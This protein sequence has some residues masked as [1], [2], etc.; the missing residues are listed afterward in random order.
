MPY[1][2]DNYYPSKTTKIKVR[3]EGLSNDADW[4]GKVNFTTEGRV[5]TTRDF[6]SSGRS[7]YVEFDNLDPGTYTIEAQVYSR[8][9][10][11]AGS[12]MSKRITIKSKDEGGDGGSGGDGGGEDEQ[13]ERPRLTFTA[14]EDRCLMEWNRPDGASYIKYRYW[15]YGGR[16][17]SGY[18]SA[19]VYQNGQS[20]RG[21]TPGETYSVR[22]YFTSNEDGYT[23]SDDTY[24]RR[25]FETAAAALREF[26]FTDAPNGKY[27]VKGDPISSLTADNWNDLMELI[28][29]A[30]SKKTSYS[31]SPPYADRGGRLTAEMYNK[32]A[33]G[34]NLLPNGPNISTVEPG[35]KVTASAINLLRNNYNVNTM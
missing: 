10:E 31:W 30:I 26:D 27:F 7:G 28:D 24:L 11:P 15:E 32:A 20:L 3:V 22:A 13:V 35:D 29:V 21:L 14:L 33:S 2:S 16:E 19:N 17:P 1:I 5:K 4:Y 25:A 34:L 8:A 6:F 18:E 9:D 12:R 23:S